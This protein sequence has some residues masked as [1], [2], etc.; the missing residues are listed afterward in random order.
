MFAAVVFLFFAGIFC[1]SYSQEAVIKLDSPEKIEQFQKILNE[2]AVQSGTDTD[3]SEISE[4]LKP[5][6]SDNSGQVSEAVQIPEAKEKDV[7]NVKK[8]EKNIKW[9][10]SP[11]NV[12][13]FEKILKKI[14]VGGPAKQ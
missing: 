10:D 1:Q 6:L 4:S 3:V 5:A 8:A 11:E 14:Q 9:L 13:E 12:E 7:K 2:G